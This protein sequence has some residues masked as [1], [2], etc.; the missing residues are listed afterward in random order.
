MN[1]IKI[2]KKKYIA[3]ERGLTIACSSEQKKEIK[4]LAAEK[5]MSVSDFFLSLIEDKFYCCP[6]GLSHIPNEETVAALEESERGEGIRSFDSIEDL[7]KALN[8]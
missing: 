5:K 8:L 4:K 7:F 3:R 1:K 2:E 6:L